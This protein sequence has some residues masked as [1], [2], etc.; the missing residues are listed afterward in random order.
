MRK[1]IV[2]AYIVVVSLVFAFSPPELRAQEG[3]PLDEGFEG[4]E[5]GRDNPKGWKVIE[6]HEAAVSIVDN[7]VHSGTRAMKVIGVSLTEDR[8]TRKFKTKASVI[9]AELY[10]RIKGKTTK[11]AF[12]MSLASGDADNPEGAGGNPDRAL[13]VRFLDNGE[14]GWSHGGNNPDGMIPYEADKW[15]HIKVIADMDEKTYGIYV[16]DMEVPKEANVP[17]SNPHKTLNYICFHFPGGWEGCYYVD[18][19]LIY[20]GEEFEKAVEGIG[21]KAVTWGYIKH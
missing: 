11:N 2:I 15:Y 4:N 1:M 14:I 8:M 5:V 18:D 9:T 3:L 7:P 19:I 12:S 6:G 10:T 16:D 13:V 20:E 17:F 21:K